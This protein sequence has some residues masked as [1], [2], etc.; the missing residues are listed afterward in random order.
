MSKII[1]V[2]FWGGALGLFNSPIKRLQAELDDY[3]T[4]GYRVQQVIPGQHGFLY[5]IYSL[6]VLIISF[7]FY[8]PRPGYM[9]I[10]EPATEEN[11]D[12]SL[13]LPST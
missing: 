10:I 7:G 2:D 12:H 4:K 11:P 9:V 5:E 13:A 1:K 6:V 3:I 8:Q